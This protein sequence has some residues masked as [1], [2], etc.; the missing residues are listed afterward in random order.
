MLP[1]IVGQ[2]AHTLDRRA[3]DGVSLPGAG[4]AF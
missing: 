3:Q 1:L 2:A 4:G